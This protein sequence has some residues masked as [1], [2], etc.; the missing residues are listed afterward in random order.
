MYTSSDCT[1]VRRNRSTGV[2][3]EL[4]KFS[5]ENEYGSKMSKAAALTDWAL[6]QLMRDARLRAP[7]KP[8]GCDN[9]RQMYRGVRLPL[10]VYAQQ[11][12]RG[13]L[14]DPS[15]ASFSTDY[16]VSESFFEEV[17]YLEE[18]PVML[19]L[20]TADV[21]AGTPWLWFG[22][23]CGRKRTARD[24]NR[25]RS[26]FDNEQ[27]VLLPP[28][29][30]R[31]YDKQVSGSLD[32]CDLDLRAVWHVVF[33]PDTAATSIA[34][35]STDPK[36]RRRIYPRSYRPAT[37]NNK[38]EGYVPLHQLLGNNAPARAS[39]VGRALRWVTG[40]KGRRR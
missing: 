4:P 30:Y 18:M 17:D 12:K 40:W 38:V 29:R 33:E 31:I 7:H 34:H 24:K 28:G 27:E 1:L 25:L 26:Q 5:T 16:N 14:D 35:S 3:R 21:P 10:D 23:A 36:H 15:F 11:G 32:L 37:P 19:V 20:K 2:T 13:Y 39:A 22:D 6:V 8:L 9:T